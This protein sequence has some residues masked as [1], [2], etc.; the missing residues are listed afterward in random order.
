MPVI[1]VEDNKPLL[2]CA[3]WNVKTAP[4]IPQAATQRSASRY[5]PWLPPFFFDLIPPHV[6]PLCN[7]ME[8]SR[9]ILIPYPTPAVYTCPLC[10]VV[11]KQALKHLHI[12]KH[13]VEKPLGYVSQLVCALCNAEF[14]NA[15]S[16]GK[17]KCGGDSAPHNEVAEVTLCEDSAI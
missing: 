8:D 15:R 1:S 13:V 3:H 5:T 6:V 17:H 4:R 11:F 9:K 2:H 14:T 12:A 10:H 16:A 7:K